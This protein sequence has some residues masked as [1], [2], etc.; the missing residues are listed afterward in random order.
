MKNLKIKIV[1]I[2]LLLMNTGYSNN[3]SDSNKSNLSYIKNGIYN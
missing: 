2:I 1:C 3:I